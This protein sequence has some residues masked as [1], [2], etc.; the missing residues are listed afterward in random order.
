MRA[1]HLTAFG[2]PVDGLEFVDIPEPDRPAA[3]QVLIGVQFSPINPNDSDVSRQGTYAIRPALPSVSSAMK[4]SAGSS[5]ADQGSRERQGRRPCPGALFRLRLARAADHLGRWALRPAARRGSAATGDAGHQPAHG[6]AHPQRFRRAGNPGDWVVQNS[7]NSGVGRWVIAFAKLRA[8]F[9]D[10]HRLS[11]K[12]ELKALSSRRIGGDV[13]RRRSS[14][15]QWTSDQ[16]GRGRP[17]WPSPGTRWGERTWRRV[18]PHRPSSAPG[19]HA[20]S[21]S[22]LASKAFYLREPARRGWEPVT[23]KAVLHGPPGICGQDPAGYLLAAAMVCLETGPR[24][25]RPP[26]MRFPRSRKRWRTR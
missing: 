6:V 23:V 17:G 9:E 1:V 5:V 12:P 13:V 2:N 8:A 4:A 14:R 18:P 25:G 3:N 16:R 22:A 26:P 19:R 20:S 15:C 21:A 11:A 10:C 24:T 7:A